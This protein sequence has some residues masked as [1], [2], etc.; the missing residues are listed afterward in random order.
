MVLSLFSS[1][2]LASADPSSG[3]IETFADG[4]S[5]VQVVTNNQITSTVNLS[6]QRNTTIDSAS[7]NLNY[8]SGDASPGSL[9]IDLDSDGQYEWHLGGNGDGQVGE[10]NEFIGGSS[11]TSISANGN[12]TW[13]SSGA[14]R[15]PKSALM[16]SSDI[17]VGFTPDLDAQFSGVGA[18]SDLTVGDMDG[19]GLQDPIY[20]VTNHTGSN[21][22]FW[23]HIGWLKWSGSA[24]VTNWIPTCFDADRLIVG[25]SDNDGSTDILAVAEGEDTLCQHLSGNSWSYTTNVTMNEKFEDALLADMD[26]DGQDDLVSIDADGTLGMR[27]FSGG[28][29]STAVTATVTSGNMIPGLENFVHVGVGSFYGGNQSIIVGETDVMTSYNSIWNFSTGTWAP[30]AATGYFEC[31]SG[32]FEIFDWNADGS[33]DV[34]GPTPSAACTATWNGTAW[35]TATSNMVGLANYTIGD[36]DGDGTIDVFRAFE[37]SP[38][39]SDSTQTGSLDMHPFDSDGSVN[40]TSTSFNPHT[41]PRDIVFADLDGDGLNEQIVAAGEATPGLFIGAWHTLEWDLESDGTMEMAMS[42]YASTTNP[43]SQSDQGTLITN[44]VSEL[45]SVTTNYDHYD[46]PWGT[47]DPVARSMGAGTITQSALN[48]SYTATFTVE[49]NPTNGNLSNVLNTFMLMGSGD[50]DVPM[51]LTC[52]QNGTVTLDTLSIDWTAGATNIQVPP[53][54]VISVFD[55]NYSQVSLMWT[56]TTSPQDLITYQLFRAPTG[57]Q[58]S[59]NQP[60]AETPMFG[61]QDSDGVTNQEWDYAVRSVHSFGIVSN[62]SNIVTVNVP[63]VPPV[64]DTTPPDAAIVNLADV[65]NDNGGVLNLS[66]TPSPSPDLAYT[67]FFVENNDFTNASGLTP[68]ANISKE[69]QAITSMLLTGLTDGED[70]WAAAVTVDGDDNAWWNVTAIGPVHSTNDTVRQSTLTLDVSGGGTYDDG[71]YSGIHVHAGSPFSI[72]TQLSSEGV[73]LSDESVDLSITVDGHTWSTTLTT[74]LTG[75]ASQSWTDWTD[76]VDEWE[77]H[78]GSGQV[79]VS[80]DGGTYGAA[81]QQISAISNVEDIV[82]TVDATFSTNTPSIQL[83]S[84]GLGT[85]HVSAFT[86]SSSEQSVIDGVPINWQLGNGTEVLGES[87]MVQFDSNGVSSIPVDYTTG[88][89]LNLTPSTPWW[90]SL[91]PASLEIDLYPAVITGCM[92]SNANNFDETAQV[93]GTCTYDTP[94][95]IFLD[96][97]NCEPFTHILENSTLAMADIDSNSMHCELTNNN[98]VTVFASFAFSYEQSTPLFEDDLVSS[99]ISMGPGEVL[100]ITISPSAWSE[101]TTPANGTVTINIDLTAPDYL[102]ESNYILLA[103][104]FT[105]EIQIDNPDDDSGE[106]EGDEEEVIEESNLMFL[107]IIVA[108]VL[109]LLGF[110]GLRM[111]MAE[112]EDEDAETFEDEEWMPKQKKSIRTQPD[113]DDMPTGRSLDEL[114]TKA[115]PVSMSKS[116]RVDRRAGQRPAPVHEILEEEEYEEEPEEEAEWDYTQ[117]EDYHVDDEGVEWWKDEVGQWWYKYP[118]DDDW[119]AFDE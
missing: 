51:N 72:S 27:S 65:P 38:D 76:F 6:I 9:T 41:S 106:K 117:D 46:T 60:L 77:A 64:Y 31:S 70:H 69:N 109:G 43:L 54:P 4:S 85:A 100:S 8:D 29:Y 61:Y 12:Q 111:A 1:I 89:W 84:E 11:S 87:G 113:M 36:H 98:P 49:G 105:E 58:I 107:I 32:P 42:G 73:P 110:V 21:G 15:L 83:D 80:W 33:D 44:V 55:F 3:T 68:Y 39:G 108:V 26:G 22:T 96:V 20:L 40:A 101:G 19:D 23:P 94:Q 7:F 79:S 35:N 74:G 13:L 37:G 28:A 75:L 53:P 97:S 104:G 66:F 24:I 2:P 119:E 48:M 5:S 86:T 118:E 103:Y 10:Q 59:I 112:G 92:D 90:L 62:L 102:G 82:A 57:S 91:S 63:D 45:V 14:W 81:N 71:T 99:E 47:M 25:D 50:I 18:V 115:S 56:N 88:G 52:T 93:N 16:A 34:M 30:P 95:L 114:T 17:T 78:G 116:K 67:L